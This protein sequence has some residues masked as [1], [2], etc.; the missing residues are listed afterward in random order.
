MNNAAVSSEKHCRAPG[1]EAVSPGRQTER[2]GSES[3]SPQQQQQQEEHPKQAWHSATRQVETSYTKQENKKKKQ[4]KQETFKRDTD[5]Y[6][7]TTLRLTSVLLPLLLFFFLSYSFFS[8]APSAFLAK[9]KKKEE[10]EEGDEGKS[11]TK[12][13]RRSGGEDEENKRTKRPW[14]A[15]GVA[16]VG[17]C[18]R[19]TQ[20]L[21]HGRTTTSA[22]CVCES[23]AHSVQRRRWRRFKEKDEKSRYRVFAFLLFFFGV[24]TSCL[25]YSLIC[26]TFCVS[27]FSFLTFCVIG[28]VRRVSVSRPFLVVGVDRPA[29]SCRGWRTTPTTT[30]A[31]PRDAPDLVRRSFAPLLARVVASR[32]SKVDGHD[33]KRK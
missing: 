5:N 29:R 1:K 24:A 15:T 28:Y 7:E 16:S 13:E 9:E 6:G 3:I 26:G 14:I 31:K 19:A 23:R 8:N 2:Q 10:K 20:K 11:L 12:R 21:A 22:Q 25:L 30:T 32:A 4:R 27:F 17:S 33:T 18:H